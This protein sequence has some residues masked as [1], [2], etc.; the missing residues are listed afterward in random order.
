MATRAKDRSSP[1]HLAAAAGSMSM[2]DALLVRGVD[3]SEALDNV[4]DTSPL[5]KASLRGR[6]TR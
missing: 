1:L 5:I 3:S 4:R 6:G 2:T